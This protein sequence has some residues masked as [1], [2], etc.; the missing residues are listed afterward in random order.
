MLV[1]FLDDCPRLYILPRS[2]E[3]PL[4][5]FH[6]L[7]DMRKAYSHE[8]SQLK[9]LVFENYSSM[10]IEML[11]LKWLLVWGGVAISLAGDFQDSNSLTNHTG[12]TNIEGY[13]LLVCLF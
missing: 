9:T 12:E 4:E 8:E 3:D 1:N 2:L 7:W 10:F 5:W 11:I 13:G 6:G